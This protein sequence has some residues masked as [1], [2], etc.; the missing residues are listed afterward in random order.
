MARENL[1]DMSRP[2]KKPSAQ[3]M[4]GRPPKYACIT[5]VT[6]VIDVTSG[7][8][9]QEHQKTIVLDENADRILRWYL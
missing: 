4:G 2:S 8:V 5:F 9:V 7:K 6:Q 1:G 3:S